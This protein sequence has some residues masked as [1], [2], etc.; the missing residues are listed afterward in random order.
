MLVCLFITLSFVHL[1]IHPSIHVYIRPCV[2]PSAHLPIHPS[3]FP[4]S[5]P[6][7][8]CSVIHTFVCFL[9]CLFIQSLYIYM[10]RYIALFVIITNLK[11]LF[12][13]FQMPEKDFWTKFFQS[14]YFHR[15]RV[16]SR[17]MPGDMFT[18]CAKED[19]HGKNKNSFITVRR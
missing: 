17:P 3:F 7:F 9:V 6:S 2:F 18:E 8:I 14:H 15:D 11:M 10:C 13:C 16:S 19:E 5:L 1:S 4:A 12:S